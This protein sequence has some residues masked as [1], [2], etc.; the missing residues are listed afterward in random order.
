MNDLSW[1]I[2]LADVCDGLG[3]F[4]GCLAFIL[5]PASVVWGI[6]VFAVHMDRCP[7]ETKKTA[8]SF[9]WVPFLA[10]IAG[11]LMC[12]TPSKDT[13]YAIAA[14]EVGEK[15]IESPTAKKAVDALNAWL[16]RQIKPEEKK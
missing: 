2:Y 4:F 13:V 3:A 11:L 15:V 6:V 14:S 12:L 1:L 8:M 5:L 9:W 7:E 10:V 16:D